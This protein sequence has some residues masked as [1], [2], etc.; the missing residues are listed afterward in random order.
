MS[1]FDLLLGKKEVLSTFDPMKFAKAQTV[2]G[3]NRITFK[4]KSTYT[5]SGNRR[6]GNFISY[7]ERVDSE[8]QYQIF[9]SKSQFELATHVLAKMYE[10]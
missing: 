4:V 8:T 2:L 3:K 5:G 7:G 10:Q 9:V 1:I 6:T